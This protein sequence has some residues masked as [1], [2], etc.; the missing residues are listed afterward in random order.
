[1][2]KIL[3]NYVEYVESKSPKTGWFNSLLH[4]FLIG[5]AICSLGQMVGD[6]I[7]AFNPMMD[8]Q[9]VGTWS[10]IFII[11]LTIV[12]T[13]L[14]VFDRIAKVGGAGTFVPISGF[15]NSIASCAIE[16]KK[17]GLVFGVGSK[18]FFVAGP[19][20]VNGVAYSLIVGIVYFII[21]LF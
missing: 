2:G 3:D 8:I 18:M 14:G 9:M 6:I 4:A 10:S 21:S 1:M 15:A 13:A 11:A 16:Y 5:G 12:L 17:E 7:K 20:L 19:V